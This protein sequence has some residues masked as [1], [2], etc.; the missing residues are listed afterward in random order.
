MLIG[1]IAVPA[2]GDE[3]R[4]IYDQRP[5][6]DIPR[7]ARGAG[8]K[9][10]PDAK[11]GPPSNITFGIVTDLKDY[12]PLRNV[13]PRDIHAVRVRH[14]DGSFQDIQE[15][16]RYLTSVLR[17]ENEWTYLALL[18]ALRKRISF[19]DKPTFVYNRDTP[20][21]LSKSKNWI[22]SQ[23][24]ALRQMKRPDVPTDVKSRLRTKYVSALHSAA[25]AELNGGRRGQAWR[26]HLMS[27]GHRRGWRYVSY[28]R[29]LF[30][31]Y[32]GGARA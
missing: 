5:E 24:A 9:P 2:S 32:D 30:G 17:S 4:V 19:V 26:W 29:H 7:E 13:M 27:L 18:L 8:T 15:V 1:G 12:G 31:R 28:T 16:Q 6:P 20:N 25:G 22:V 21:A 3:I 10:D 11:S 23:P 14:Y